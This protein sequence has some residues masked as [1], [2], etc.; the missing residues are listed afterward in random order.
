MTAARFDRGRQPAGGAGR[1]ASAGPFAGPGAAVVPR[2][3]ASV[4]ATP[5]PSTSPP[6]VARVAGNG[7]C[8]WRSKD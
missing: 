3:G 4:V 2:G 6:K 7:R 1:Q 8:Q 5:A